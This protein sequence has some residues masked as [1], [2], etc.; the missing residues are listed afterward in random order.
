MRVAP[1]IRKYAVRNY[2]RKVRGIELVGYFG[3]VMVAEEAKFKL[4]GYLAL[5][6]EAVGGMPPAPEAPGA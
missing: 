2:N 3:I 5:K 6:S 1:L 4:C